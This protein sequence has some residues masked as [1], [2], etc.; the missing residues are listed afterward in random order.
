[1]LCQ[2][3]E[4]TKMKC[5]QYWPLQVN[6]SMCMKYGLIIECIKIK[7][8]NPNFVYTKLRLTCK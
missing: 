7:Q 8:T 4:D 3:I 6:G 5:A 1:M 2:I